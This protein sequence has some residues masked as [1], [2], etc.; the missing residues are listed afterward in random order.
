MKILLKSI[1]MNNREDF[2]KKYSIGRYWHHCTTGKLVVDGGYE[3]V[4]KKKI[5]R[6]KY[7]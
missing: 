5:S 6:G 1:N 4:L 3:R 7:P 2:I